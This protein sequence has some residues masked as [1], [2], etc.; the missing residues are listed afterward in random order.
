MV[1]G[2]DD[3]ESD[4]SDGEISVACQEGRCNCNFEESATCSAV[5]G[6]HGSHD[7]SVD[8][9]Q[10]EIASD[11][12]LS[13]HSRSQL[14]LAT[15]KARRQLFA[16]DTT[17][18]SSSSGDVQILGCFPNAVK[19][20]ANRLAEKVAEAD[21]TCSTQQLENT[22]VQ[23]TDDMDSSQKSGL[24]RPT[25]AVT[26]ASFVAE[27]GTSFTQLLAGDTE[28]IEG[29]DGNGDMTQ[30]QHDS[31]VIGGGGGGQEAT[32]NTLDPEPATENYQRMAQH[33][34]YYQERSTI[35]ERDPETGIEVARYV[36]PTPLK[37]YSKD[38]DT[39]M[40]IQKTY[41]EATR[42][43]QPEDDYLDDLFTPL[44]PPFPETEDGHSQEHDVPE[45]ELVRI[46][47]I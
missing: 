32:I 40:S 9:H 1:G 10:V 27:P 12:S 43:T 42:K 30:S 37:D 25:E 3:E 46:N 5:F 26:I 41:R 44:E 29:T 28:D 16:S 8:R 20:A 23:S 38:P 7:G 6:S 33:E 47:V 34:E 19:D 45:D 11:T 2:T 35:W 15:L 22:M 21:D 14:R 4:V 18:E 13:P 36:V 31:Q 17:G 39:P 24:A